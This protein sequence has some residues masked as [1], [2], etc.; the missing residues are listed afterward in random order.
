MVDAWPDT[1]PQAFQQDDYSE[2]EADGLL[3]YAPDTGP[4]ITRLRTTAAM[5]PL[6]GSMDM[7]G[8][9]LATLRN[10]WGDTLVKGSLPFTFPDQ[11]GGDPLLVKFPKGSAPSWGEI[12]DDLY[13]VK[14]NLMVLP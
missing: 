7:T 1:L 11:L 10:F 8:V 13:R 2:A 6:S 4:S 3:E 12:L 14:I 5:R 9:Q